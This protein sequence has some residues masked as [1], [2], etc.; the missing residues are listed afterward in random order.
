MCII[1]TRCAGRNVVIDDREA[2][3]IRNGRT[4]LL[5]FQCRGR[6]KINWLPSQAGLVGVNRE[7]GII[8]EHAEE[9]L[10]FNRHTD[11][12]VDRHQRLR[13]PRPRDIRCAFDFEQR[14]ATLPGKRDHPL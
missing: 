3:E 1:D 2:A 5:K 9:S 13:D 4:F 10:S 12:S 7:P 14:L 11:G 8:P 6:R